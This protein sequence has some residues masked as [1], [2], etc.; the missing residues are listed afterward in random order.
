ML[1]HS[2]V[3]KYTPHILKVAQPSLFHPQVPSCTSVTLHTSL[4]KHQVFR[5][6]LCL[7]PEA[8]IE[9][10]KY[11]ESAVSSLS[12]LLTTKTTSYCFCFVFRKLWMHT[13]GKF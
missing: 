1:P 7:P 5:V 9:Y 6:T 3:L 13:T 2:H 10:R 12:F 4:H 8:I 11:V